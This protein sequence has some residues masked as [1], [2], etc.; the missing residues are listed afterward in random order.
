[1]TTAPPR[2]VVEITG[3]LE[4]V[5]AYP[6]GRKAVDDAVQAILD[7]GRGLAEQYV[8]VKAYDRWP[9]QRSDH[10]YGYGP[11]HGHIWFRVGL[12][13]EARRR[14]RDDDAAALTAAETTEALIMLGQ[15]VPPEALEALFLKWTTALS[16]ANG[17]VAQA[18]AR[19][20][21][22]RGCWNADR[23]RDE[24]IQAVRTAHLVRERLV[25]LAAIE[26]R[27]QR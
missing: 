12:S 17:R 20:T 18:M 1:M 23:E 24:A 13:P 11:N 3:D 16:N 15:P 6:E 21:H 10:P 5:L 19:L 9:A 22:Y 7:G 27:M 26:K 14:L 4:K 8:G 25:S 2:P